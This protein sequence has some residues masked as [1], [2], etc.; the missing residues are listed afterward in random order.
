MFLNLRIFT[1]QTVRKQSTSSSRTKERNAL[2]IPY[3][4]YNGQTIASCQIGLSRNHIFCA[5][6]HQVSSQT[7]F[8]QFESNIEARFIGEFITF[9]WRL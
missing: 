4:V 6:T 9:Y 7:F 1:S 3:S 5:M 8:L 2:W